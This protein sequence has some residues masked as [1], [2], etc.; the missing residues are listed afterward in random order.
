MPTTS[1]PGPGTAVPVGL[2]GRR[3]ADLVGELLSAFLPDRICR[4]LGL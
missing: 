1:L 3:R 2:S 4:E